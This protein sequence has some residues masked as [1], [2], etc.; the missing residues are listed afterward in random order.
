MIVLSVG[1]RIIFQC[2]IGSIHAPIILHKVCFLLLPAA[3]FRYL[4][5]TTEPDH[6]VYALM[7]EGG[8]FN[9]VQNLQVTIVRQMTGNSSF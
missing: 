5:I 9:V 4:K 2:Y 8:H 3:N 1:V 6:R 7:S